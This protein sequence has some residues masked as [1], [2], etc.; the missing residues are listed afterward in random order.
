MRELYGPGCECSS[1]YPGGRAQ[2]PDDRVKQK[3]ICIG[4]EKEKQPVSGL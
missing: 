2:D 1:E 4:N 3:S